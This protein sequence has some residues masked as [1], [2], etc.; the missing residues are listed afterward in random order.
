M[1]DGLP[2]LPLPEAP[3]IRNAPT[4]RQR[5]DDAETPCAQFHGP[6]TPGGRTE[7]SL[8]SHPQAA[9]SATSHPRTR[10]SATT[11]S[12]ESSTNTEPQREHR[13][14]TPH[15]ED[16]RVGIDVLPQDLVAKRGVP[17]LR[18][19]DPYLLGQAAGGPLGGG[20]RRCVA[21]G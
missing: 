13:F 19:D 21:D 4:L 11:S 18:Q 6:T 10:S 5:P 3:G 17:V 7:H 2:N 8:F 1:F 9:T 14:E 16:G 15:D 12:A 20:L